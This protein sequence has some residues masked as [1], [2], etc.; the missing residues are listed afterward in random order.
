MRKQHN[1]CSKHHGEKGLKPCLCSLWCI[2]ANSIYINI[3]F[4]ITYDIYISK[5][6]FP[7]TILQNIMCQC[8]KSF[9]FWGTSSPGLPLGLCPWTPL[10]TSIPQTA[11]LASIYSRPLWGNSPTPEKNIRNLQKFNETEEP[12]AQIHGWMTLLVPIFLYCLN[13]T[14]FGQLILRK[15]INT[16]ATRCRILR[17]KCT[18]FDF[19]WG[20]TPDPTG[21]A[22][23]ASPRPL[24]GFKRAYF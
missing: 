4:F 10:G 15:I 7:I 22:Y 6:T 3:H 24:A 12:Q 5:H 20:S 11:W 8:A 14:K 21:G 2:P 9:S 1:E 23:S 17:L 16:V 13:C 18:K 19:G